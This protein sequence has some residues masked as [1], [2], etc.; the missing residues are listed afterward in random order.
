MYKQFFQK[1]DESLNNRAK[2]YL[3]K[4]LEEEIKKDMMMRNWETNGNDPLFRQMSEERIRQEVERRLRDASEIKEFNKFMIEQHEKDRER[5]QESQRMELDYRKI[6][7]E[8]RRADEGRRR[9]E[10][11]QS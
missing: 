1:F 8:E 2:M 10:E 6:K 3:E 9:L 5:Q 7:E 4:L 11:K